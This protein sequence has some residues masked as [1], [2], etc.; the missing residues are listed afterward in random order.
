MGSDYTHPLL[1]APFLVVNHPSKSPGER[2]A[3]APPDAIP[4]SSMWNASDRKLS[5]WRIHLKPSLA[6]AEPGHDNKKKQ[7][8]A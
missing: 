4:V 1:L 2:A 8:Q 6:P 3:D 5:H 7:S